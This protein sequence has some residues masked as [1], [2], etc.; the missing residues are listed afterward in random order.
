MGAFAGL[1]LVHQPT[2]GPFAATLVIGLAAVMPVLW[3]GY[4]RSPS[5]VRAS[6]RWGAVAMVA[7]ILL[8]SVGF[9]VSALLARSQVD[10][11]VD[12]A[13]AGLDQLGRGDQAEGVRSL[14]QASARFEDAANRLDAPWAWPARL[15]PGVA[16][17]AEALA[18]A[19]TAGRDVTRVAADAA[20]TAPYQ[21]LKA[22]A[23][24][25][26]LDA[27]RSMQEP[28]RA[29]AEALDHAV[30]RLDAVS[31]PWLLAPVARPIESFRSEVADAHREADLASRTLEALP[32]ILGGDGDRTYLVLFT[33][34]AETRNLGGFVGSYG[35][36]HATN[37]RVSFDVSGSTADLYADAGVDPATISLEAPDDFVV[38]YG[39]YAPT[40]YLQNL[41]VSPDLETTASVARSTYDQITGTE[42]DGVIVV[43]P[44]AIAALLEL[45]GPVE[46]DGFD[47]PLTSANATGYLLHGQYLDGD[48]SDPARRDR[49]EA[50]G[51]ATFDALTERQLPGPRRIGDV[52][53][54]VVDTKHLA[55][56]PFDAADRDLIVRLGAFAP[57]VAEPG[58][59]FLSVRT[60]DALA[61]KLDYFLR[62]EVTYSASFDPETQTVRSTVSITLHNDA[63]ADGLPD[64]VAGGQPPSE[65]LAPGTTRVRIA[66]YTPLRW[67]GGRLAG[68]EVPV[69]PQRELGLNVYTNLITIAPGG[70]ATLEHMLEGTIATGDRYRLQVSPQPLVQPDSYSVRVSSGSPDWIVDPAHP[71]VDDGTYFG[72]SYLGAD[73]LIDLRFLRR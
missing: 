10:E 30:A 3:S 69:E 51:R 53:G 5:R 66:V 58:T 20:A 19:S 43:D 26:D 44:I 13:R 39:R 27:V 9:G 48:A 4:R 42:V 64:Y 41:T 15:V 34:P 21:D 2:D 70:S 23:G 1:A 24:T 56:Y 12:L 7:A 59:D 62:K 18:A 54:P 46:V 33:N 47:E 8:C 55:F 31:S 17:H 61:N 72:T 36:L 28:V 65:G 60:A 16:P 11:A 37:G 38:R 49:L 40:T 29:T 73:E 67:T 71:G 68:S 22:G 6:T 57:L 25:V 14:E 52:L 63:P 32:H 45:T 35:I 50:A